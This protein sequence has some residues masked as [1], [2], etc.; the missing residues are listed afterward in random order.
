MSIEEVKQE[1]SKAKSVIEW[2]YI[3]S[4]IKGFLTVS[5]LAY[6]DGCGFIKSVSSLNNW[7]KN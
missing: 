2:N 4:E 5:E 6:I 3:R 7:N 1:L